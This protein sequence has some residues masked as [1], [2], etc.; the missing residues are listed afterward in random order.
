MRKKTEQLPCF[1]P[2]GIELP[3]TEKGEIVGAV[4]LKED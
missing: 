2:N 1:W 3:L 4:G